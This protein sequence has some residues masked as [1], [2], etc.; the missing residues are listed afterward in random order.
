MWRDQAALDRHFV[1]PHIKAWR[2]AWSKLGI[3]D[4]NLRVYEVGD[5][6]AT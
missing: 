6:R 5:P 1:S 4:R 2:A 3:G